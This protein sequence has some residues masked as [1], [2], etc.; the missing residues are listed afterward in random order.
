M[1]TQPLLTFP[2]AIFLSLLC[3]CLLS[4]A[5]V[6]LCLCVFMSLYL[7]ISVSLFF[8]FFLSNK[9]LPLCLFTMSCEPFI[10]RNRPPDSPG[11]MALQ[12][13][14]AILA[15]L[16]EPPGTSHHHILFKRTKI[17]PTHGTWGKYLS[18]ADL[19]QPWHMCC[20]ISNSSLHFIQSTL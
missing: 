15:G 17:R 8:Y 11:R 6:S 12:G 18:G 7:S 5:H 4:C 16:R 2:F 3:G 10:C 20:E 13:L 19:N 14:T 9:C 1:P